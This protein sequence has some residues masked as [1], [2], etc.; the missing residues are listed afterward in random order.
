MFCVRAAP[1]FSN[2]SW[3]AP[4]SPADLEHRASFDAALTDRV[5]ESL[6]VL[7]EALAAVAMG[8]APRDSVGEELVAALSRATT[9]RA[10]R[11]REP[12]V[13][14][15]MSEAYLADPGRA[16][17]P[18]ARHASALS[19]RPLP[20]ERA[21]RNDAWLRTASCRWSSVLVVAQPPQVPA[22]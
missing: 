1:A 6:C 15:I 4:D 3:I 10:T 14:S 9:H 21:K 5:D 7:V 17:L 11:T 19:P 12:G 8:I 22:R 20:S 2:S 16:D 18:G 13:E